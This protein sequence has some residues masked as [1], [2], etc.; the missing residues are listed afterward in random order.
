MGGVEKEVGDFWRKPPCV[1]LVTVHFL[2]KELSWEA[3]VIG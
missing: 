1:E 3:I 2:G